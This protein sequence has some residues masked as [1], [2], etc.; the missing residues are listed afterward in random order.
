[1]DL[2][3]IMTVVCGALIAVGIAGV[4]VPILPGSIL[5]I[6]ALLA[7]ALTVASVEGWVVFAIGTVLAGAGLAAGLVLTGRSLR[8]RR[9]PGRSVTIGVVLGIVGMFVIPVVGLVVGF[10]VG[11]FASELARQRDARAALTSSL[12]ALKATGLGILAELALACLAGTTWVIGVW[13]YFATV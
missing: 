5:I 10:V 2:E 9:I 3:V 4:V 13:V 12:H 11:L 1:M 7:W 8:Q 6:V